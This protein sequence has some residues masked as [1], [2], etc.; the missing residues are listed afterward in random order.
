MIAVNL[1]DGKHGELNPH[2]IIVLSHL[3]RDKAIEVRKV[4][5]TWEYRRVAK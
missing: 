1:S 2:H 5:L 3:A 4:G